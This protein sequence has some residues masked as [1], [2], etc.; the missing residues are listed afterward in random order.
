MAREYGGLIEVPQLSE[1]PTID[2]DPTDTVWAEAYTTDEFF[3][4]TSRWAQKPMIGK[5]RCHIGHRDG[6]IYI[7]VIG[8]EDDLSKII[9]PIKPGTIWSLN[10]FRVRIGAAS[11]HGGIWPTFGWT[12]RLKLYPLAIFK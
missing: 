11:E 3:M 1:T 8:Y 10:V 12:Q 7:A 6:K 4:T 9:L 2:G 5:S